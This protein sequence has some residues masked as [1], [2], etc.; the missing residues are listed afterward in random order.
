MLAFVRCVLV[1]DD[2]PRQGVI[3]N[4]A[5]RDSATMAKLFFGCKALGTVP[6]ES[7]SM[8]LGTIQKKKKRILLVFVSILVFVF[9]FAF[10]LSFLFSSSFSFSFSSSFSFSCSFYFCYVTLPLCRNRLK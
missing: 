10:L 3:I 7:E 2:D 9:D 4:G 1:V 6:L 5:I 8:A